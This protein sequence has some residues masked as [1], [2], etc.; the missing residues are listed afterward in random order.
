MKKI[1]IIATM[2]VASTLS[3]FS[4]DKETFFGTWR[5]GNVQIEI[6]ADTIYIDEI[7]NEGF[8][9]TYNF[10]NKTNTFALF[11]VFGYEDSKMKVDRKGNKLDVTFIEWDGQTSEK[12]TLVNKKK[13]K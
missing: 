6:K 2:V 7:G 10:D 5:K 8:G 12:L 3:A 1:F 11:D 13:T 9:Y 4:C